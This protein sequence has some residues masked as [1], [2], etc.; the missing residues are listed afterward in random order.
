MTTSQ[1]QV[2]L[3][4][5]TVL[6]IYCFS[7]SIDHVR[8]RWAIRSRNNT[9]FSVTAILFQY[10]GHGVKITEEKIA[11][12]LNFER[13]SFCFKIEDA[14]RSTLSEIPLNR[15]IIQSSFPFSNRFSRSG[16]RGRDRQT[17]RQTSRHKTSK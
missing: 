3:N 14:D 8:V 4:V 5:L 13:P 10:G 1:F 12:V 17:D 6:C 15:E 16:G 7:D 9:H 2:I 11:K